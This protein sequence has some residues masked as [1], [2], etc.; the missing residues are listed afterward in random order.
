MKTVLARRGICWRYDGQLNALWGHIDYVLYVLSAGAVTRTI[1]G[2]KTTD[3]L[4]EIAVDDEIT[5]LLS[6]GTHHTRSGGTFVSDAQYTVKFILKA[7]AL[8]GGKE[9]AVES[10]EATIASL[11]KQ[12]G[13][14]TDYNKLQAITEQIEAIRAEIVLL[15]SDFETDSGLYALMR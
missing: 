5:V 4:V 12:Y 1:L 7:S 8:I 11:E 6:D 3:E 9:V 2:G 14:E 10:K 13:K 15:Y